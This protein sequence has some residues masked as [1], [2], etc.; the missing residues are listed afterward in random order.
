MHGKAGFGQNFSCASLLGLHRIVNK[1]KVECIRWETDYNSVN[2]ARNV[3]I[4]FSNLKR[5]LLELSGWCLFFKAN[6]KGW[7]S[8]ATPQLS[9]GHADMPSSARKSWVCYFVLVPSFVSA[10]IS[11]GD[12]GLRGRWGWLGTNPARETTD[13]R[14]NQLIF[15]SC[16]IVII[17]IIYLWDGRQQ[18]A[19]DLLRDLQV[20]GSCNIDVL[21]STASSVHFPIACERRVNSQYSDSYCSVE[22]VYAF[23]VTRTDL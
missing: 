16:H 5:L 11:R 4:W 8:D 19:H 3:C 6:Y 2:K 18:Y 21:A 7:M 14:Y 10:L 22:L 15:D 13:F 1:K 12:C 17:D 9:N 20:S 23:H